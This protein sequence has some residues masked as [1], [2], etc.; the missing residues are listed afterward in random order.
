[1]RYFGAELLAGR[2]IEAK[3]LSRVNPAESRLFS[4]RGESTERPLHAGKDFGRRLEAE[5]I[6]SE[7]P[8]Q[9]R[10]GGAADCRMSAWIRGIRRRIF[11]FR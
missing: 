4:G 2:V 3:M 10:C 11:R 5:L 8:S 1:M 9:H 6:A 7:K